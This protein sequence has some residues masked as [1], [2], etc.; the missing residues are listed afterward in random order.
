M[1]AIYIVFGIFCVVAY[2]AGFYYMK[3]RSDNKKVFLAEHPDAARI[4]AQQVTFAIKQK[5][6]RICLVDGQTPVSFMS[7]M[8][9][10]VLVTPGK[11]IL[12]VTFQTQRPGIL[13]RTVYTT[14]D[15]CKIEIE[16]EPNGNYELRFNEKVESYELVKA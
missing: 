14:Y 10:G 8:R 13:Y 15:P 1:T 4:L 3:V 16:V 2:G 7:G 11:H 9:S 5:T 12:E 6:L